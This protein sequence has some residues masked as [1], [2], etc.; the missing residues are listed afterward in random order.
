[1]A[2]EAKVIIK[3]QNNIGPA[4][5]SAS[6]DLSSM[7][8]AADK[9]GAALKS[10]FAFTAI[11]GAVKKLG[12]GLSQC[13]SEFETADRA[14]RQLAIT[15]GDDTA[16]KSATNTISKLTKQA[17]S[18]KGDIEAMVSELAAL[19]KSSDEI[20]RI[21]SAAVYL[22]NVTGQDLNSAMTTL[23]RSMDGNTASLRKY[24]IDVGNLT[25]EQLQNGAAIDLVIAKF[26][27]LSEAMSEASA[28]QSLKNIK[29][30]LGD[31]RQG[32]GQLVSSAIAPALEKL[33]EGLAN[34]RL[35]F[36]NAV[37]NMTIMIR[38]LPEV[39]SHVVE[40][41]KG[42][43]TSVFEWENIKTLLNGLMD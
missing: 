19:G 31:I 18:S 10:A 20:D 5:K 26:G 8:A 25:K 16:Y 29:D 11:V 27:E 32:F 21:S 4:I 38:N 41:L 42:M 13:F 40:L 6:S 36:Q 35:N 9:L 30:T 23:M 24:G 17:L 3:G 22:S 2:T 34:F 12:D 37:D 33:D 28:S 1:M 39:F 14:Y 43:F 15:L 7:K